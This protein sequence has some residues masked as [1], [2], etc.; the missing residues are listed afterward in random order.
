M[1]FST[2]ALLI[3]KRALCAAITAAV[4]GQAAVISAAGMQNAPRKDFQVA[5]D[6]LSTVTSYDQYTIFDDVTAN[7]RN[8]VATLTGSVTMP[9]KKT[10]IE[11]RV[12]KIKGITEVRNDIEVLPPSKFDEELRIRIANT[13]Y[14]NSN[15]WAY[16][17][18]DKPPIHIIVQGN[19]VMLTGVVHSDVDRKLA[20]SLAM[21]AGAGQV[22]NNLKTDAEARAE[23]ER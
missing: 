6:I 12:R 5:L 18:L 3:V 17:N 8:G 20:Q 9:F 21:Q 19:Q 4:L 15:F 7:V 22:T 23:L 14:N 11:K 13:I 1:A 16:A 10:E 2:Q